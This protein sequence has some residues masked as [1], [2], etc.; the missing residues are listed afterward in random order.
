MCKYAPFICA[1]MFTGSKILCSY[2][3]KLLINTSTSMLSC[4]QCPLSLWLSLLTFTDVAM[5]EVRCPL[6]WSMA[7]RDSLFRL[8]GMS[9]WADRS[10]LVKRA[11]TEWADW[12]W[13]KVSALKQSDRWGI[14]L[15]AGEEMW[16]WFSHGTRVPAAA[17]QEVCGGRVSREAGGKW[18]VMRAVWVAEWDGG[19][20]AMANGREWGG[21]IVKVAVPVCNCV[22][23]VT[24]SAS[25]MLGLGMWIFSSRYNTRKWP[26]GQYR[27]DTWKFHILGFF[28]EE[29][30]TCKP[31]AKIDVL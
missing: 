22:S 23:L 16:C 12:I 29:V 30:L 20:S 25:F 17:S 10:E 28:Y 13:S 11:S 4:H 21:V 27:R 2:T 15:L 1:H 24:F 19:S 26:A 7:M 31:D 8:V 6:R 3:Q 5:E 14:A 9:V 18:A